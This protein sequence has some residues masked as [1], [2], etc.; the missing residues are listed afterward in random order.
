[1]AEYIEREALLAEMRR[2]GRAAY[3]IV[4]EATAADVVERKRGEWVENAD[5]VWWEGS[6]SRFCSCCGQGIN[7]ECVPWFKFCP[8]C[9]AD[10]REANP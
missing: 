8:N 10:M 9:G 5:N 3:M 7:V 6:E 4:Q 1:M 2:S